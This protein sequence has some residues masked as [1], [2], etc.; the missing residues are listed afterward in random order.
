MSMQS[1]G[2]ADFHWMFDLLHH[3]DVGLV[4]LDR[5]YK[6]QLWNSFMENHSG[7]SSSIAKQQSLFSVF[8]DLDQNWLQQK[9]DNVFSL[10]TPIYIS[11]EQRSHLFKFTC[12]RPLTSIADYMYQNIAIRPISGP[13]GSINQV[14][15]VVYDVTDVAT[16]KMAFDAIRQGTT[17]T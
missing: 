13:D 5:Q 17:K 9:L 10:K 15:L 2:L 1:D 11:W 6:V 4:V 14:C 3:I 16:N 8:P 12:Y 7:V